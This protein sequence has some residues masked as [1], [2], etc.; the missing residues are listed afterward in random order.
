VAEPVKR[1][2]TSPSVGS[3]EKLIATIAGGLTKWARIKVRSESPS[4]VTRIEVEALGASMIT[5]STL[6]HLGH[7]AQ[8]YWFAGLSAGGF[9]GAVACFFGATPGAER[10]V[11]WSVHERPHGGTTRHVMENSRA[12]TEQ[13]RAAGARLFGC[14]VDEVAIT[15]NTTEGVNIAVNGLE[16]AEGD[17]VVTTSLATIRRAMR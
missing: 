13:L 16:L 15:G 9:A 5:R 1:S 11:A 2:V 7:F 6:R 8:V 12:L 4:T 17:G 14:D 10:R 3:S